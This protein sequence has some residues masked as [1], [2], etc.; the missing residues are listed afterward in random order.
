MTRSVDVVD[1]GVGG[2]PPVPDGVGSSVVAAEQASGSQLSQVTRVYGDVLAEV[3]ESGSVSID[4]HFFDDLGVD[5]LVMAK[6]CAR[7]RKRSGVPGASMKDIYRFP[8]VRSLATALVERDIGSGVAAAPPPES[9]VAPSPSSVGVA[10]A[11]ADTAGRTTSVFPVSAI[12]RA[13]RVVVDRD[14][15]AAASDRAAPHPSRVMMLVCGA[16]QA[17][18]FLTYIWLLACVI[19]FDAEWIYS[20]GGPFDRLA[21]VVFAG[22]VLAPVYSWVATAVGAWGVYV[23]AV[24]AVVASFVVVCSLPVAIKWVLVGRWKA[25]EFPVWGWTYI[26]FWVVKTAV[27][28]NPVVLFV[29]SPLFNVYLRALGARIGRGVLVLTPSVP[30]CTDLLSIGSGSVLRKGVSFSCYR[31]HDGL[32]QTGPVRLGTN[33]FVSESTVLDIDTA[34]GDDAQLGHA[35]SLHRGQSV[36]AGQSWHGTP[37]QRC[38]TDFRAVHDGVVDASGS[39]AVEVA[40]V[41]VAADAGPSEL[42]CAVCSPSDV[43]EPEPSGPRSEVCACAPSSVASSAGPGAGGSRRRGISIRRWVFSVGQLVSVLGIR[44]PV[45]SAGLVLVVSTVPWL[46]AATR[47]E[48]AVFTSWGAVGRVAAVTAVVFVVSLAGGLLV[49]AA[50]SRVLRLLVAPGRVYRL[51]GLRYWAHR[52]ITRLTNRASMTRLFG[53]S[54]YIVGYL[55]Y[56]GYDL[57]AVEQTGSNFGLD[58]KHESPFLSSVGAGTMVADGLSFMNADYT[59]TSFRVSPIAIG[60]HNFLGNGIAYPAGGR[61]GDNCLLATKVMVPVDV[62]VRENV[63]LLG[64]PAFEIPRTVERDQRFGLG[65]QDE[66]RARLRAKNRHNL[67]TMFLH[68]VASWGQLFGLLSIALASVALYSRLGVFGVAAGMVISFVFQIAYFIVVDRCVRGLQALRPQGCSIYDRAFWRHERYWKIADSGYIALFNGTPFKNVLWR[69]LGVKIGRG[70]FD[71]G[72]FLP[73]RTFVTIGDYVTLNA[74]CVIQCH[75]QEDGAF[76]SDRTAIGA[77]STLG[78]GAFVHYG[79]VIAEHVVL[80]PDAFVMKGEQLDAG[81]HWTGNPARPVAAAGQPPPAADEGYIDAL[82][83]RISALESRIEELSPARSSHPA[84]K[85]LAAALAVLTIAGGAVATTNSNLSTAVPA[86]WRTLLA[87]LTPTAAPLPSASASGEPDDAPDAPPPPSSAAG[88]PGQRHI[89]R[90][91]PVTSRLPVFRPRSA[92]PHPV[93]VAGPRP[94]PVAAPPAPT[95]QAQAEAAV[96]QAQA[97]LKALKEA[98]KKSKSSKDSSNSTGSGK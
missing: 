3:V 91:T 53:D 30:V 33:V 90:R 44:L 62:P 2:E 19:S 9:S 87:G 17:L 70:V 23:R 75:S 20:G 14:T 79:V 37:A 68:L 18:F 13:V 43:S 69:L 45:A 78:V 4:D 12:P 41:E 85:P 50:S 22:G 89:V 26:R 94:V 47:F 54:S 58:V 32:I 80:D 74:G 34:M 71:D 31:A 16:V 42:G 15:S 97:Q 1:G 29:G 82:L 83:A 51:Y 8:T 6:F 98:Q 81:S 25:T 59:A 56:L 64:S 67:T 57:S 60:A 52:A 92:A 84:A 88:S 61:T 93:P 5:S 21:Q 28:M 76:K 49:V 46:A 10:G 27:R 40:E 63:G 36:P 95:S 65:D 55:R 66:F 77:H 24:F 11:S 39:A 72:G 73:E 7:I 38:D 96:K 35:S 86:A 48:E